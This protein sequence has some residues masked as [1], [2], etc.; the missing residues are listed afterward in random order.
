[1]IPI[2]SW[3]WRKVFFTPEQARKKNKLI[4]VLNLKLCDE[5][6]RLDV[7]TLKKNKVVFITGDGNSLPQDV[8]EFMS[9][10]I[11]HDL[12]CVNRSMLFFERQVDHW[13]AIDIEE[14][15][16]FA[17]NVNFK[18]EPERH[19]VRHTVGFCDISY[20]VGWMMDF[21]CTNEFQRR[22]FVGNT[23][24]FALLT[25][26]KMGYEKI[27]LGGMPLDN[28]NHWYEPEDAPGPH[29]NGM[30]Y[31]QWMQFKIEHPE[32]GKVKSMG[33]YSA[34][35]LGKADKEWIAR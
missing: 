13:A 22:V 31:I 1:M 8:K 18:V 26:L 28:N 27:V 4:T 35:I 32:A 15:T 12:Y 34:F 19:I 29:W 7:T 20:D 24:Y 3:G 30:T 10:G 17:E 21:D 9:W 6:R 23:G 14:S 16:W 11:P 5:N 2:G 33:G 25:S